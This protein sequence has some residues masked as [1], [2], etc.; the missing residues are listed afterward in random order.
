MSF[1][2]F[3]TFP[4]L[5]DAAGDLVMTGLLFFTILAPILLGVALLAPSRGRIAAAT[6]HAS[7][8]TV[9]VGVLSITSEPGHSSPGEGFAGAIEMLLCAILAFELVVIFIAVIRSSPAE[10][11]RTAAPWLFV[12]L[13]VALLGG[14]AAGVLAWSETSNRKT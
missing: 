1:G 10:R 9:F 12:S 11:E 8:Y 7:L 6:V 13:T 14:W 2:Y 3:G 5:R 4:L